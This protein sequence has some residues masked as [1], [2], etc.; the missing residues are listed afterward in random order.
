MSNKDNPS[1]GAGFQNEV[2][3]WFVR[4]YGGE[5]EVE[6]KMPIGSPPKDHKFDIVE[7]KLKI[8]IE[9]KC[10]KWTDS[11]NVPSAKMA[12]VNEAAFYLSFLP[13][14]YKKFIVIRYCY[15]QKRGETLA[16]YYYR[17]YRH[18]LNDIKVAEYKSETNEFWIIDK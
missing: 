15:H 10:I 8:A 2:K 7:E 3:E 5:F 1:I 14:T 13:S 17:T 16:Q 11:G 9:C 12:A 18:L 4:N 6:I